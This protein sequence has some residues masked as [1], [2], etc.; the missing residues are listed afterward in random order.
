MVSVWLQQHLLAVLG[1]VAL[2]VILQLGCELLFVLILIVLLMWSLLRRLVNA[3]DV[4]VRRM[5]RFTRGDHKDEIRIDIVEKAGKNNLLGRLNLKVSNQIE[6]TAA[7][8]PLRWSFFLCISCIFIPVT[9]SGLRCRAA[10]QKLP[11][12]KRIL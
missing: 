8:T 12:F 4:Q 6:L 1:Q 2:I 11:L 10:E 7:V 3:R 5:F 9:G